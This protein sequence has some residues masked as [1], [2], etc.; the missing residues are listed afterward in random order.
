MSNKL[1]RR[2]FLKVSALASTVAVISGCNVNLQRKE[3]LESFVMPP[4]EGLP[5]E[6]LW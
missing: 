1:T 4:E 5:G 2:N 6:N 3:Y